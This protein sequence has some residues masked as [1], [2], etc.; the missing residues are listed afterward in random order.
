MT[1]KSK[2]SMSK[3]QDFGS[4]NLVKPLVKD[5]TSQIKLST[6]EKPKGQ[7]LFHSTQIMEGFVDKKCT[8]KDATLPYTRW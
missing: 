3:E 7:F 6:Y 5:L 1:P 2:V 4:K 8:I